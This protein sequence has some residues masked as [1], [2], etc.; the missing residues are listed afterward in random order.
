M[1]WLLYKDKDRIEIHV[2][3]CGHH[4][5]VVLDKSVA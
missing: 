3:H 5:A 4:R 1:Y 2:T